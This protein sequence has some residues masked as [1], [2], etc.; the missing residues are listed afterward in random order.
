VRGIA[1][2]SQFVAYETGDLGH[3]DAY[4]SV[5][6]GTVSGNVGASDVSGAPGAFLRCC[7]ASCRALRAASF[8]FFACL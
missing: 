6:T 2:P 3:R 7:F 8:C 1:N 5:L 4:A